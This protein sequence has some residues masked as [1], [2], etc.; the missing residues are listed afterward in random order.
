MPKTSHLKRLSNQTLPTVEKRWCIH[1][2]GTLFTT[3]PS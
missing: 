3:S 1:T 2:G